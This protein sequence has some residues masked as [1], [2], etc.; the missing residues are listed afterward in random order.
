L[1]RQLLGE[2]PNAQVATT[3]TSLLAL[4]PTHV[5]RAWPA[6]A[7]AAA[8]AA[9]TGQPALSAT[10]VAGL[11]HEGIGLAAR[12]LLSEALLQVA[13]EPGKPTTTPNELLLP[14]NGSRQPLF[15][16]NKP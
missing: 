13:E 2:Q 6:A 8:A 5:A 12:M 9:G 16:L 1:L 7:A 14:S 10:A 3:G 11:K 15:S 4:P